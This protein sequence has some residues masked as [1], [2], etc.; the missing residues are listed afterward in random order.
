MDITFIPL[1]AVKRDH[2]RIA[3]NIQERTIVWDV[4][5]DTS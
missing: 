3:E 5:M 1:E 2:L 4:R